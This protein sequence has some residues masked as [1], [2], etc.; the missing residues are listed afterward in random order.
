M[1]QVRHHA[2]QLNIVFTDSIPENK[3]LIQLLDK[4][5][6]DARYENQYSIEKKDLEMIFEKVT[7]LRILTK[8]VAK[9]ILIDTN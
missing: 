7:L 1:K 6:I 3:R 8:D 2:R 9:A 4:A 5:Y